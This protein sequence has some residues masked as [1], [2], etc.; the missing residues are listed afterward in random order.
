MFGNSDP[1]LAGPGRIGVIMIM[2]TIPLLPGLDSLRVIDARTIKKHKVMAVT[3]SHIELSSLPQL[4]LLPKM[5]FM[6]APPR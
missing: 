2:P 1:F 3:R 6:F 4:T 5:F